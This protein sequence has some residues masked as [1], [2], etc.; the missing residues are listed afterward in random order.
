[1]RSKFVLSEIYSMSESQYFLK[2]FPLN[3]NH[4]SSLDTLGLSASFFGPVSQKRSFTGC[5]NSIFQLEM[6]R[7]VIFELSL[8]YVMCFLCLYS[9]FSCKSMSCMN[10]N[11]T[12]HFGICV[13]Y[14]PHLFG[15][16]PVWLCQFWPI[17]TCPQL[18]A[19]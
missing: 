7:P 5:L 1:M 4:N 11:V 16:F 15:S 19:I 13:A 8:I 9:S 18:K 6:V 17:N 14:L 10:T 3:S 2:V 12:F